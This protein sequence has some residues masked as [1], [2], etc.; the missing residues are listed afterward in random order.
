MSRTLTLALG[1]LLWVSFVVVAL[2]HV[3]L[4]DWIGPALAVVVVTAVMSVYHARRR[5]VSAS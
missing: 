2:I 5:A 3:A 4:G 1:V